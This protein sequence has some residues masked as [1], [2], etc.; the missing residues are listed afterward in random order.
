MQMN[1]TMFVES[2]PTR[3]VVAC[4]CGM[5]QM[6][7]VP[8]LVWSILLLGLLI[9]EGMFGM[10]DSYAAGISRQQMLSQPEKIPAWLEKKQIRFDQIP[11]PHWKNNECI[12]CHRKNPTGK[13][14]NLRGNSI[15]ELCEYCHRG[16]FDHTYIHPTAIPLATAMRKRLPKSFSVNLDSKQRLSCATCHEI[17]AQCLS[18]RRNE[19]QINPLFLRDGPYR[20]RTEICYKCHDKSGYQRR[21]AHDQIGNDGKIKEYTCLICHDKTK[22]L[23]N[24]RSIREVGFHVKDNLIWVCS[25]CHPLRPHPS[26]SFT[27]TSKGVPDH[28]VVP[29]QPIR[30]KMLESEKEQDVSMPLDPITGRVFCGTCHNPHEKGVIKNKAAAKG[31]DGRKR[32][33]ASNICLNCHD[34]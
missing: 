16:R 12:G 6:T 31:A 21:N 32:L 25:G 23:D 30:E 18:N 11:N 2:A 29:P 10:L 17:E 26:G 13:I 9:F 24:A 22:G 20:G 34:K 8:G 28:L 33:R 5:Q 7:R 14:L 3:V 19:Q 15:D 4:T 27:M 1:Q